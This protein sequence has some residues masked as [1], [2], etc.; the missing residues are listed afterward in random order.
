MPTIRRLQP[1]GEMLEIERKLF[2]EFKRANPLL[3]E[4]H[5]PLDDWDYLTL[6]QHFGLPTRLLDWSNNALTAMWFATKGTSLESDHVI[7]WI[8]IA[9]EKDFVSPADEDSVFTSSS[10]KF[11]N[12]RL[13]KQRINSQSGVFTIFS[14][15]DLLKGNPLNE[16]LY[17]KDKMIK[18]KI[19]HRHIRNIQTELNTLGI[20]AFSIFPELEGLCSHL[21]WRY[22]ER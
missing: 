9:D 20:N 2:D 12:P 6:G 21:Q 10:T 8:I 19:P 15:D 14:S 4:H 1:K 18:V 13:I 22:F 5:Q 11:F 7:V 17:Y 16:N 3:I